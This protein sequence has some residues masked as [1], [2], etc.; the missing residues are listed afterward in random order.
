MSGPARSINIDV[1]PRGPRGF[2][3]YPGDIGPQGNIGEPGGRGAPGHKVGVVCVH[4][5][6]CVVLVVIDSYLCRSHY[7]RVASSGARTRAYC[8]PGFGRGLI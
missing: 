8:S 5:C 2:T 4:V 1:K 6:V 3:G 7:I